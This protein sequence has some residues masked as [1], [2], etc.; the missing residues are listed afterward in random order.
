MESYLTQE[1]FDS[2]GTTELG[3]IKKYGLNELV[4]RYKIFLHQ[5]DAEFYW[6]D[7]CEATNVELEFDEH[8]Y[9][10]TWLIIYSVIPEHKLVKQISYFKEA[11]SADYYWQ[12]HTNAP[13]GQLA[14]LFA[15]LTPEEPCHN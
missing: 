8:V 9:F 11:L 10:K 15:N 12:T 6:D 7:L 1:Q 4:S 2:L 13:A 14:E 5:C 3:C